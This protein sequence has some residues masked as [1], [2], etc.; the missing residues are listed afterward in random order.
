MVF[1]FSEKYFEV[2]GRLGQLLNVV[3]E[4][5]SHVQ[6]QEAIVV[7]SYNKQ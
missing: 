4:K 3:S 7:N 6:A 2:L 1:I 5:T